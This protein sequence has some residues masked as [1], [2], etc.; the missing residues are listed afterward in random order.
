MSSQQHNLLIPA[1]LQTPLKQ[2][3]V[4]PWQGWLLVTVVATNMSQIPGPCNDD[5]PH[6]YYYITAL[7]YLDYVPEAEALSIPTHFL[8]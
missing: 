4:L 8:W 7:I 6:K 5:P 1:D 3:S 2:T